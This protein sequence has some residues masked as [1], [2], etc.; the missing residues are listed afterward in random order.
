MYVCALVCACISASVLVSVCALVCELYSSGTVCVVDCVLMGLCTYVC[1]SDLGLSL[2][3][4]LFRYK[5]L[6]FWLACVC[7]CFNVCAVSFL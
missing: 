2:V 5:C 1:V 6:G 4:K 7:R 3:Y